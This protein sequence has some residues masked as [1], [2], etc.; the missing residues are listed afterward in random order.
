MRWRAIMPAALMV[1]GTAAPS[2]PV[3]AGSGVAGLGDCPLYGDVHICS[4]EIPSWDGSPL[5]VDLTLPQRGTGD[6]H[7]LIVMLHGFAN[8]KHEWESVSDQGDIDQPE[9]THDKW[10]WNNHWFAKH[11]FY[12]LTYTARGFLDEGKT[13]ADEPN[14]P[15]GAP[16]GSYTGLGTPG[17][18]HLKSRDYEI[19]DTAWL[20][21]TV[22]A[23]HSD[24]DPNAVAVS[25]GSY[26]G[27]ESW[28]LASQAS[29]HSAHD[30]NPALPV[31]Q[32][33]VAVPH[34]PWTDLAY[35]LAPNGHKGPFD[36]TIYS[37]S[38][39]SPTTDSGQENPVGV[40]KYSY[41]TGFFGEGIANGFFETTPENI[42]AWYADAVVAGDP[43]DGGSPNTDR[44]NF[45]K[46]L[47]HGLTE[48]RGAFYQDESW[49]AQAG[50]REVAIFSVS[51]WTD[52]LFPPV[53][54]FRQFS[55]LKALDRLW[56]VELA[57]GDVG[58]PLAQNPPSQ[59]R[60]LNDRAWGFLK[61][62][63]NG[64]H[65]K[66]TTVS[67]MPTVCEPTGAGDPTERLTGRTP[68]ALSDGT[69]TVNYSTAG[70]L[71]NRIPPT[72]PA[73]DPR[74]PDNL[75]TD[76]AFGSA[77]L[78][79][80]NCRTSNAP[81]VIPADRYTGYSAPLTV[82]RIYVGLGFARVSY[83]LAG[84]NTAT[85]NA[86]VWD[87]APDGN[88][89]L[90][91]RGVYRIDGNA[92][93]AAY[94]P[95]PSGTIDLPLFGNQWTLAAGHRIRLDLTQVDYPTFLE[96]NSQG[97]V[98]TFPDAQLVLPTREATAITVPGA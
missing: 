60:H 84:A 3:F 62:Q 69:L 71:V 47:R 82:P 32:L 95:L 75:G 73:V 33:Q 23:A 78:H 64:S 7:P 68:E 63:I 11:G 96:S 12:V 54:A 44:D 45:I 31:L 14:T 92:S 87:V 39:G 86:R 13:R 26:G 4:G 59:W 24:L 43:Y 56:P 94:D 57:V 97:A 29:W 27:G 89:L 15:P 5:D 8:N 49:T 93:P 80:P 58:H 18:V 53:E 65:R 70:T 90:V 28:T 21:A 2:I 37:S 91:T 48:L 50:N 38:Q 40:V 55:Y 72:F 10:H 81:V 77:V 35:S 20:A 42:P 41:A 34:Y 25:G 66:E 74:D 51:G 61:Q 46:D 67:S 22:A 6:H 1:L 52:E 19:K 85:V 76:P 83:T 98:F 36:G 79:L 9:S 30:Q 16:F 17:T 88:A